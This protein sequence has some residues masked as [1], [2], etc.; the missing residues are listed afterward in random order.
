MQGERGRKGRR[1]EEEQR[2]GREEGRKGRKKEKMCV[3]D[4]HS[5]VGGELE[6][7]GASHAGCH[8]ESLGEVRSKQVSFFFDYHI[9]T[10]YDST[11]NPGNY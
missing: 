11:L 10:W 3:P 6:L 7:E 5:G 2:G 1:Q 8:V 9:Q 4:V